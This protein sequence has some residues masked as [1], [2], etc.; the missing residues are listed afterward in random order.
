MKYFFFFEIIF[1]F[2]PTGGMPATACVGKT[3]GTKIPTM[4]CRFNGCLG[5]PKSVKSATKV[6]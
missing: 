2:K 5:T 4:F 6:C 1:F 3:N